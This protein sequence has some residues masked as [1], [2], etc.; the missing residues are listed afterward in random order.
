VYPEKFMEEKLNEAPG[1]CWI[2]MKGKR[3][4]GTDLLAIGYTYNIK[5]VLNLRSTSDVGS[6]KADTPYDMK[7]CDSLINVCV[8]KVDKPAIVSTIV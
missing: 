7:F 1:G 8:C 3:P 2:T 5:G 4:L 6:T